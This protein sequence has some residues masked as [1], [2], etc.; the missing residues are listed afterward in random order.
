MAGVSVLSIK[1]CCSSFHNHCVRKMSPYFASSVNKE[2][3]DNKIINCIRALTEGLPVHVAPKHQHHPVLSLDV[4]GVAAALGAVGSRALRAGG[5]GLITTSTACTAILSNCNRWGECI[6]RRDWC[7]MSG[8]MPDW[9][10][11]SFPQPWIQV[12]SNLDTSI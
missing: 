10:L 9:L 8:S 4:D 11:R 3:V 7:I 1:Y 5:G 2:A 12:H 6:K